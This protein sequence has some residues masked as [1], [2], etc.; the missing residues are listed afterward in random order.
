[1]TRQ[2][3]GPIVFVPDTDP[4]S[5]WSKFVQL[6]PQDKLA[7]FRKM[8]GYHEVDAFYQKEEEE[9][10]MTWRKLFYSL[11]GK[12]KS[13]KALDAYNLYDRKPD[14]QNN[15]GWSIALDES[16]YSP[17]STPDFGIYLVHLKAVFSFPNDFIFFFPSCY[18]FW[19][20][21]VCV[22]FH[23]FLYLLRNFVQS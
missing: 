15:N 10:K 13:R 11:I 8:M 2:E 4:S 5:M 22:I 16:D 12:E 7:Y 6:K 23:E 18:Y 1:M 20:L 9:S 3:S 17:L 21:S 14:F 19:L